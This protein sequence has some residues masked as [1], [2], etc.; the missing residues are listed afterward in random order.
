MHLGESLNHASR[1]RNPMSQLADGSNR[2]VIGI[3]LLKMGMQL[4]M[5]GKVAITLSQ[6]ARWLRMSGLM[7]VATYVDASGL[8]KP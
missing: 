1:V 2:T 3:I 5:L 7:V 6:M 4:G 8:W